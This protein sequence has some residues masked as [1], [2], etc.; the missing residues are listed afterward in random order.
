MDSLTV[1]MDSFGFTEFLT[2]SPKMRPPLATVRIL[3][4]DDH[5]VWRRKIRQI[6]GSRPEWNV[7]CEAC[8]G[9]QAV[10][11]AV[12]LR[13]DV[14]LLDI[15][16]PRLNGIA[17]AKSIRQ[18][19]PNCKVVFVTLNSDACIRSAALDSGARGYVLKAQ[20]AEELLP[21]IECAL[22]DGRAA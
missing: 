20:A 10:Q 5:E 22:R 4:A 13:P 6:L 16:M 9:L 8:D 7:L 15:G 12:E 17:V 3:V 18:N 1:E 11:K 21:A 14:V 19:S 2:A